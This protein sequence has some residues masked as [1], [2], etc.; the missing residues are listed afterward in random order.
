MWDG[1]TTKDSSTVVPPSPFGEDGNADGLY[2][3][4][5]QNRQIDCSF[6]STHGAGNSPDGTI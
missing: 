2:A 6:A 3:D 4:V 5:V 1:D